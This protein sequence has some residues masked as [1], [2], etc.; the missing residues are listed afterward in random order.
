M[1]DS[2]FDYIK[3]IQKKTE[4]EDLSGYDAYITNHSF[5]AFPDTVLLANELNRYPELPKDM[6]FD[7]YYHAVKKGNRFEKWLKKNKNE[8]FET[9]KML[10]DYY[11]YNDEKARAALDILRDDQLDYIRKSFDKG[12][13]WPRLNKLVR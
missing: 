1:T 4:I 11:G 6:Q 2:P 3:A 7:F 13:R 8:S 10:K 12:G 9:I 5:S